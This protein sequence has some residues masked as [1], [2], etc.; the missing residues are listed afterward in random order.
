M[1]IKTFNLPDPGEGLVEAEIVEWKVSPGDTVKVNDMVLEIETAKSL[2]EL[3]IPWAGTVTAL[4]VEVGQTVDVG[5]PIISDRRRAR[6]ATT[7]IPRPRRRSRARRP[8]RPR[9]A[10]E[11]DPRR[12]RRQGR[13]HSAVA[14]QGHGAAP[15]SRPAPTETEQVAAAAPVAERRRARA[16][17]RVAGSAASHERGALPGGR[18]KAKPPVRKLAKDLGIDL[19]SVTAD[20]RR[21]HHHPRRRRRATQR[22]RP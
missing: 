14:A 5:T 17:R 1:A 7:G 8:L 3:P 11:A 21:R 18:P 9:A 19:A 22:R 10:S 13:R 20:G 2:V 6:A 4:L 12:L 16:A 15:A